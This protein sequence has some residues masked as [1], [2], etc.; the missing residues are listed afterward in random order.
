METEAL[1]AEID[2]ALDSHEA[3]RAERDAALAEVARL[4]EALRPFAD[5]AEGADP[6]L[7]D[8]VAVAYRSH[9]G[10]GFTHRE[11]LTFGDLRR[12]RAALA[13][14]TGGNPS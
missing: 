7:S 6:T 8:D 2:A 1:F 11:Q 4:R 3:L 12:A 13:P 5:Y 9:T 14:F 10:P